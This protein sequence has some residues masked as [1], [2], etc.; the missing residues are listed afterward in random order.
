MQG[1]LCSA[2]LSAIAS[3]RSAFIGWGERPVNRC[4][5]EGEKGGEGADLA[6]QKFTANMATMAN[7][8]KL[9]A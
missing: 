3:A 1:K 4:Y 9:L 2:I 7:G 6:C 8:A 5:I